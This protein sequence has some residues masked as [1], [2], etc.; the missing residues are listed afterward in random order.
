MK[1]TPITDN[2]LKIVGLNLRFESIYVRHYVDVCAYPGAFIPNTGHLN[3]LAFI[4]YVHIKRK[5]LWTLRSPYQH[6]SV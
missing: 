4:R 1:G 2:Y 6:F 3:G 5:H